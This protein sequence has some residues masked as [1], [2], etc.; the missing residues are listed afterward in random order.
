MDNSLNRQY[1]LSH[2]KSWW[3]TKS[4]C[5]MLVHIS[6]CKAQQYHSRVYTV[7]VQNIT[8]ANRPG[9]DL[10][11]GLSMHGAITWPIH[12]AI[13]IIV[14][15]IDDMARG[16][17]PKLYCHIIHRLLVDLAC[18]VVQDSHFSGSDSR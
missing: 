11:P 7:C 6:Q 18:P 4:F 10:P 13:D 17:S 8:L 3:T 9:G 2:T 14:L 5:M 12:S 16:S 1:Q 15:N